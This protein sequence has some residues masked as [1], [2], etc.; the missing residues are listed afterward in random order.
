VDREVD[1]MRAA[2]V[3]RYVRLAPGGGGAA[4]YAVV[5]TDDL[6]DAVVGAGGAG[7]GGGRGGGVEAAEAAEAERAEAEAA[8]VEL[9]GERVVAAFFETVLPAVTQPAVTQEQL[10]ELIG[11][12]GDAADAVDASR[13][14]VR[15]GL[16]VRKDG[17]EGGGACYWFAVPRV[18][19]FLRMRAR[20]NTELLGILTRAPYQEM[21]LARLEVRRLR[22]SSFPALFHIR[23]IV[24]SGM[25][26][27]VAT[28]L[29]ILVRIMRPAGAVLQVY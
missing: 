29:G 23:D 1:A 19:A 15:G 28:S 3:L 7:G 5:L 22:S 26:E 10:D 20:G 13:V 21:L 24:G 12:A 4:A 27:S 8:V 14:L 2:N 9:G 18:G 11:A 17:G 25:A 6:R 16:L